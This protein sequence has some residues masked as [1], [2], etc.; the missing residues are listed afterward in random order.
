[1]VFIHS[2]LF[3]FLIAGDDGNGG[4]G[5]NGGDGGD[6][7]DGGGKLFRYSEYCPK[8]FFISSIETRGSSEI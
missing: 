5:G 1:M 8:I 4:N 7:G 3:F 6:G 2:K